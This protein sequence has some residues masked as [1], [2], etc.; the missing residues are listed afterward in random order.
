MKI[1][2]TYEKFIRKENLNDI[3]DKYYSAIP[4]DI[5]EKIVKSDPTSLIDGQ[6]YLGKYCKWLL[7]LYTTKVLK[8]EDLYKV[9]E[10][11]QL[12]DK[13]AVRNKLPLEKRNINNF[14][15]LG[16]LAEVIS[17]FKPDDLMS[18][19]E[20][21]EDN[22]VEE[23]ENYKLYI[24]KDFKDSCILGKGTEWC[25]ATEKTD[26]WFKIYHKPGRELLIFISKDDPKEKYQ[27]HFRTKQFMNKFDTE[28]DIKDFLKN[29]PDIDSWLKLNVKDYKKIHIVDIFWKQSNF[30]GCP[31]VIGGNFD[32]SRN[33]LTSLKGCAKIVEGDLY[34]YDNKL[35]SLEGCPEIVEGD[36]NCSYNY[37]KDL[38]YC[39]EKSNGSFICRDNNLTSLDGCP[40]VI[41]GSFSCTENKLKNLKGCP[42]IIEGDFYCY[43]NRLT[44]FEGCP[45]IL[46]GALSCS[47]NE[48]KNL[49]GCPEVI[50]GY[51]SCVNNKLTSLQ[52]CAKKI[53]L[54]FNCSNNQ[55]TSLQGCAKKIGLSFNCSNNQLTSLE[56]CPEII[57]SDFYCYNNNLTS[58]I[59]CPKI[60][61]G[62][63]NCSNNQL[64][65]L[66]G[67]PEKI[68]GDFNCSYNNLTSLEGCPKIIGGDFICHDNI[69]L[70]D[71]DFEWLKKNCKIGERLRY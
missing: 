48:L 28:I 15:N 18:K 36:F 16:E 56:G 54:S 55:L 65:S 68:E 62:V 61:E 14:K 51:F 35:T 50:D 39:F 13:Q 20:I 21:K 58:L 71:N 3:Y 11:L 44:S 64:T 66:E 6:L 10:Y 70:T 2:K 57:E 19:K 7:K 45:K 23:F 1:L 4:F 38:K 34:Y 25:T 32:C 33:N 22:L 40:K 5:F 24:P 67:S 49:K 41:D 52:G 63:F 42:E 37:L 59:G 12:F 69:E 43:N 17:K 9:T 8:I 27:F 29:N 31:E 46:E 47:M 26:K 60:V 30:N 53:G